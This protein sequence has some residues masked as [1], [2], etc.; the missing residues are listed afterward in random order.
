MEDLIMNSNLEKC[1]YCGSTHI[2]YDNST[3]KI[4]CEYCK[5]YHSPVQNNQNN[6][7]YVNQDY[8]YDAATDI[9]DLNNDIITLKCLA[10]GAQTQVN[11]NVDFQVCC[12]WCRNI[13]SINTKVPNGKVPDFILPFSI[14]RETALIYA[15]KYVK[16]KLFFSK[17]DFNTNFNNVGL[18]G[19]YLPYIVSDSQS[20][21]V[22]SGKAEKLVKETKVSTDSGSYT[23]Y[24]A[25]LF[26]VYRKFS[27]NVHDLTIE[28]RNDTINLNNNYNSNNI[29]N[30]IMP[31]DMNN[32]LSFKASYINGFV[33]EKRDLNIDA[34]KLLIDKQT[35]EIIVT[36]LNKHMSKYDRGMNWE[37]QDIQSISRT[38]KT[39]LCPVWIYTYNE[40]TSAGV[41]P[42]Y[43]AVNGRTGETSGSIPLNNKFL[44]I[45]SYFICA[46]SFFVFH[47][48]FIQNFDF[49]ESIKLEYYTY[50][51]FCILAPL[52]IQ[53]AFYIKTL[54]KYRNSFTRHTYE[55]ETPVNFS[56]IIENDVFITNITKTR[57]RYIEDCNSM[58]IVKSRLKTKK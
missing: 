42:H 57:K 27:V 33:A 53:T 31:F 6:I 45:I 54:H 18:T 32:A 43:I 11:T 48:I 46:I 23:L 52:V 34:V 29:L 49:E 22:F 37:S 5:K 38:W 14:N 28:S 47:Y 15:Q 10:C 44:K 9:V 56:N 19:V 21:C 30:S 17:R 36:N 50:W 12:P 51:V 1:P 58:D 13:L 8:V 40:K 35:K 41:Y 55:H 4:F 26:S 16:D 2:K 20:N 24:D 39:A 7:N 3:N 25:N